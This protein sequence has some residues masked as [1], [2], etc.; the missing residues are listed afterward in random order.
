MCPV[1]PDVT[2]SENN[3]GKDQPNQFS[4]NAQQ[5]KRQHRQGR[6]GDGDTEKAAGKIGKRS[7]AAEIPY[8][9]KFIQN[10]KSGGGKQPPSPCRIA[11][12]VEIG[13]AQR[14]KADQNLSR[15]LEATQQAV[16]ILR[17]Y[18]CGFLFAQRILGINSKS[19]NRNPM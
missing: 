17:L 4:V 13:K 7:F 5:Q 14:T 19:R 3:S 16:F 10:H 18:P 6:P 2:D 9:P 1:D 11:V 15:P 12:P 8:P